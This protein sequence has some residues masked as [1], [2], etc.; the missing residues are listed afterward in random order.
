[1]DLESNKVDKSVLKKIAAA[2]DK[3]L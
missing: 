1:M 3:N 2:V